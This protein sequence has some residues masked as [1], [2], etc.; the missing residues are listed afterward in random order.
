M[1]R[2]DDATAERAEL[3]ALTARIATAYLGTHTLSVSGISELLELI[4][5]GLSR[6]GRDEPTK[7]PQRPAVPVKRSV[8]PDWITCLECGGKSKMLRRHLIATHGMTPEA[9][10]DK[11]NLPPGYPMTA[12]NYAAVRSELARAVGLGRRDRGAATV[13]PQMTR[14]PNRRKRPG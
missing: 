6:A 3:V 2:D 10:R 11:W 1:F 14:T 7:E 5:A 8:T 12:P 13:P 4:H 9:Y